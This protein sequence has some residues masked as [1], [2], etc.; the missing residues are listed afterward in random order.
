MK[1][2]SRLANINCE[3]SKNF[4][5]KIISFDDYQLTK[6]K[7]AYLYKNKY[8]SSQATAHIN[9]T[10][11][12]VFQFSER[13]SWNSHS[14]NSIPGILLR[15]L[16]CSLSQRD[17]FICTWYAYLLAVNVPTVYV[18]ENVNTHPFPCH[19]LWAYMLCVLYVLLECLPTSCSASCLVPVTIHWNV[20]LGEELLEKQ[21]AFYIF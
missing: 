8:K 15:E 14:Q 1:T 7:K 9:L 19:Y 6:K 18:M 11:L 21:C 2:S 20:K 12:C 5:W 4:A 13:N 10:R 16:Y 17:S 3:N